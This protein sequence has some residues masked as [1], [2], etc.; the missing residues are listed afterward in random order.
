MKGGTGKTSTSVTCATM[1]AA[2]GK[3]VLFIDCDEQCNA[4]TDVGMHPLHL[5]ADRNCMYLFQDTF[6]SIGPYIL[7]DVIPELPNFDLICS[8]Y[9]MSSVER[10]LTVRATESMIRNNGIDENDIYAEARTLGRNLEKCADEIS[11]YDYLIFDTK[12]SVSYVNENV[13]AC[14]DSMVYV[15][16]ATYNGLLGL[17][18]LRNFWESVAENIGV[19]L[20]YKEAII[21]NRYRKGN[22]VDET[23]RAV[24]NGTDLS[25]LGDPDLE[26][27]L[28]YCEDLFI[29]I[30]IKDTTR[31]K[32]RS[33]IQKPLV[34][35]TES[36]DGEVYNQYANLVAKML[37]GGIF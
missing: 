14:A 11:G 33:Y 31:M 20:E 26:D 13:Y 37:E 30:P 21:L 35:D 4:S 7:K 16:D 32:Y 24:L 23:I 9:S 25:A 8:H 10:L 2:I 22:N 5:P 18:S 3:K 17:N 36:A 29:D 1:L 27:M 15:T 34:I 6:S 28:S 19:S 12:P